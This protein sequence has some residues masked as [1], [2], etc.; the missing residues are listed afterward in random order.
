V[1][2]PEIRALVIDALGEVAPEAD[3]AQLAPGADLREELEIDSM[4]FL[5]FVIGVHRRT[6]VEVPEADYP[7]LATLDAAV[8]YLAA[9]LGD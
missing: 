7:R 6:G 2:E 1:R 4:D 8:A 9:R 5:N 3:F